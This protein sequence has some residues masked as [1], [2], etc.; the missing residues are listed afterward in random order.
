[1][2][3]T[4]A[5]GASKTLQAQRVVIAAPPGV[6]A[7]SIEFE[8]A[9]PANKQQKMVQTATWCG[10]WCKVA[11]VFSR[12]F[13][14]EQGAPTWH[15]LFLT[16][17]IMHL[18]MCSLTMHFLECEVSPHGCFYTKKVH[19]FLH[20]LFFLTLFILSHT[21]FSSQSRS[22][23]SPVLHQVRAAWLVCIS[24]CA[25]SMCNRGKR[26]CDVSCGS[27]QYLVGGGRTY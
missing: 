8:P 26:C 14:R 2:Q 5:S 4:S 3:Y 10:D 17:F 23:H 24:S 21:V 25:L 1:M 7:N 27:N 18:I 16:L 22:L 11:A 12:A 15:V 13:W 9:L 19:C 6:V 20:C